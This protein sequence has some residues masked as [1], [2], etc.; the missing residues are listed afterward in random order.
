PCTGNV[1]MCQRYTLEGEETP[2]KAFDAQAHIRWEV[3]PILRDW[4]SQQCEGS[5]LA[6]P[7]PRGSGLREDTDKALS[8][9]GGWE[10]Q[11]KMFKQP[12]YSVSFNNGYPRKG[13]GNNISGYH[14][15]S[16]LKLNNQKHVS[17]LLIS[18]LNS[19][20]LLQQGERIQ[21]ELKG[22][23]F[24]DLGSNGQA[25]KL[26][27]M[28]LTRDKP[29]GMEQFGTQLINQLET[30]GYMQPSTMKLTSVHLTKKPDM[31]KTDWAC[32]RD[33]CRHACME[34]WEWLRAVTHLK[35]GP[36]ASPEKGLHGQN[37][38]SVTA[39]AGS[40]NSGGL[41]CQDRVST[42]GEV[43]IKAPA[44]YKPD[45][46]GEA[47]EGL[48]RSLGILVLACN[49]SRPE[50]GLR[51]FIFSLAPES[52]KAGAHQS[53]A[54]EP[55]TTHTITTITIITTLTP[56][57]PCSTSPSS[58]ALPRAKER[59]RTESINS[60]FAELR[61]CI[62][63]VPADTKLSKIKTLRLATSYIAYLMDVLAKDAQAGDPEAFKA[64]LKKADGG[65]E[66]KRKRELQQHEGFPPALGPGEKRIKGRTGWP[67]Q[68][69]A[70][71]LN[72]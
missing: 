12:T 35:R 34:G 19:K 58:S 71:E 17:Y 69:W 10:T 38:T 16:D 33:Y 30:R 67:Q 53:A 50:D 41:R 42:P 44:L 49:R 11:R 72:Q 68:V 66:S 9:K 3:I 57:T 45:P 63:N 40:G 25:V 27:F 51:V 31:P 61:E 47:A 15:L 6:I 64:E 65:R 55:T 14:L 32:D 37:P 43:D 46:E 18:P 28:T 24:P 7:S 60:A 2:R 36:N 54:P 1:A 8:A 39:L 48:N 21:I 4:R 29:L 22:K 59:R 20:V 56:R 62:P 52:L 26:T 70:L 23:N 13:I 5:N